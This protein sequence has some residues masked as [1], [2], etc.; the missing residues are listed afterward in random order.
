VRRQR[1]GRLHR[2]GWHR[3][4]EGCRSTF[5]RVAVVAVVVASLF[6]ILPTFLIR[7]NVPDASRR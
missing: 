7:T 5:T 2:S 6:E 4:W 3:R 1:L